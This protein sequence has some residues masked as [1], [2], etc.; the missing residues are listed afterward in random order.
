[1]RFFLAASSNASFSLAAKSLGVTTSAV[2]QR[3][4]A[5]EKQLGKALFHRTN[6]GVQMTEFGQFFKLRCEEM[7]LAFDAATTAAKSGQELSGKL[8]ITCPDGLID[9][10]L[11]P[12]LQQFK[13][14]HP[15]L[16]YE[17]RATDTSLDLRKERIDLALRFGWVRD[18]TFIAKKLATFSEV[19]CASPSYL[20]RHGTPATP[21]DLAT[22]QWVGYQGFGNTQ[23]LSFTHEARGRA[24]KAEVVQ[25]RPT[26]LVSNAASIKI[27]LREGGGIS[28]QPLPVVADL[29]ARG[30]LVPVL[31]EYSLPGPT[32]YAVY[33]PGK[34]ATSNHARALVSELV[35]AFSA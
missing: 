1:M 16:E 29:L 18:G 12:A 30:A 7:A 23:R 6:L 35:T 5:L 10:L 3:L 14:R 15:L 20:A 9:D 31:E 8:R 32:L 28:R 21:A 25:V 19:V 34:I 17:I 4:T 13:Q 24:S 22:H 33:L 11:I 27:W 26:V 2:S